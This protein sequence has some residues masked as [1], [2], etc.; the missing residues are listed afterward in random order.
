MRFDW[1][2]LRA[3]LAT[4]EEGSLSAA[5]R[6]LG[7]AQPTLGRQV[8]ALEEEL[9]VRLFD[10]VGRGLTLTPSGVE[11][12]QH[13]RSMGE[14]ASRVSLSASGQ[15][16]AIDG[17]IRITASEIGAVLVLTRLLPALRAAAPGVTVEL[18]A[19]NATAD[20]RR[21][22]AD[23]AV[24]N[25]RPSDPAL[26]ARKLGD[27]TAR[28]YAATNYLDRVGAPETPE[29]LARLDFVGFD[30]NR[31]FVDGLRAHGLPVPPERF[32]VSCTSHLGVWELV[33]LGMGVGAMAAEVGD[34]EPTVRSAA[35]WHPPFIY[36]IWLVAHGDLITSRRVRFVFDFL[37][38]A[39]SQKAR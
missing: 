1:N 17:P 27:G 24:R 16:Q 10:R 15:A 7:V 11:L 18:A 4:A 2:R 39:L 19:D 37:A 12:L 36:P 29:D 5:A 26:I 33:K 8:S 3:F 31:P 23:I 34:A 20:L 38:E 35:P 32:V 6:A 13:A 14:A 22:E 28:L 9:G 30:D 25:A 21:R